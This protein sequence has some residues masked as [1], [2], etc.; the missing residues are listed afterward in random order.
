MIVGGG[1]RT[2]GSARRAAGSDRTTR[3]IVAM[4]TFVRIDAPPGHDAAV[5]RALGWFHELEARCSRFDANSEI[6]GLTHRVGIAVR[7]S[8]PVFEAV[9]F[10]LAVAE[11]TGGAFDP[12]IGASMEARGFDREHR[13]RARVANARRWREDVTYQDVQVDADRQ[14]ITL[15]RPLLLDLGAVAKGLAID[16]AARELAECRWFAIDA[17]GD[18]FVGGSRPHGKPWSVGIRHPRLPDRLLATV[19]VTNGAVCTS[20]D[21][22]RKTAAGHHIID[23]RAAAPAATASA[24][25]IAPNAMLADALAT[26]AFVLGG[27]DG[28]RLLERHGV[29]GL[30]VS[31]DVER[32]ATAGFDRIHSILQDTEGAP[33]DHPG[34]AA[35]DRDPGRGG[36]RRR[37][38]PG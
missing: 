1:Q 18:L 15:R 27:G 8:P 37:A 12:T 10:A 6:V 22:E 26:A 24:T 4:A 35:D 33:D 30:I 19:R 5:D 17:G 20:G 7:V 13:T 25:V 31:A 23:P 9:Q 28:I 38:R 34:V 36:Q 21:Y 16:M 11:D 3:T 14:T 32:Y 2:A 29:E